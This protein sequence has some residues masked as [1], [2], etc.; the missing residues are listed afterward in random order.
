[1][2]HHISIHPIE[3][4]EIMSSENA[5][6]LF[7]GGEIDV[8]TGTISLDRRSKHTVVVPLSWFQ[9]R[10]IDPNTFAIIDYGQTVALG[11]IEVASREIVRLFE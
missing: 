6:Q 4:K 5:S 11:G 9:L 7:V 10:D 1:M 2:K 8:E 3:L